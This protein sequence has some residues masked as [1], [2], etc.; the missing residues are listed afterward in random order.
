MQTISQ[1]DQ[2]C[3]KVATVFGSTYAC[4]QLFRHWNSRRAS[5]EHNLLINTCE[6]YL[7]RASSNLPPELQK[8][9]NKNNIKYYILLLWASCS[10]HCLAA[11]DLGADVEQPFDC[12]VIQNRQ[13]M[14]S[15]GRSM[16]WTLEDNMVDGLFFCSTLTGRRG[17]HTPFV[18][19][20]A[21]TSDTCAEAVKPDPGSSWEGHSGSVAAGVGAENPESCGVVC[22]L[23]IPLVIRPVRRTYVVV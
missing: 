13:A 8:L 19:A 20:G 21:E 23:R 5:W 10:N 18:Q 4:E 1:L 3:Q 6:I 11:L 12:L 17:S 15:M 16:E 2:S 9:S 22:P 7:L 14:Q